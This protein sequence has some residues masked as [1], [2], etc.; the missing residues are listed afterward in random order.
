MTIQYRVEYEA[1]ISFKAYDVMGKI[2]METDPVLRETGTYEETFSRGG[3]TTG[4]YIYFLEINNI[5]V[6]SRKVLIK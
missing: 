1:K 5:K 3:L 4:L 2:I 6:D